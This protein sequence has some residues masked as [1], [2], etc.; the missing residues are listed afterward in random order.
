MKTLMLSLAAVAASS[1]LFGCDRAKKDDVEQTPAQTQQPAP[2]TT[3]ATAPATAPGTDAAGTRTTAD[4]TPG[5]M[6]QDQADRPGGVDTAGRTT[7]GN[8]GGMGAGEG[9]GMDTNP[10]SP[11]GG[12]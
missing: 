11:G 9:G 4:G 5:G 6:G 8:P 7:A 12:G 3:P 2:V 10:P 1:S